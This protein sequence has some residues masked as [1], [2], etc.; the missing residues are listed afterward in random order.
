MRRRDFVLG[1]G[2]AALAAL[3]GTGAARAQACDEGL[4]AGA[5]DARGVV[6]GFGAERRF[7]RIAHEAI[8]GYMGA[9]TMSFAPCA[10]VDLAAYSVGDRVRFRFASGADRRFHLLA[11]A[12]EGAADAPAT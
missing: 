9:M 10:T 7:V 4:E 2:L 8:E 12:H 3:L 6:V 5:H 11:L 1:G